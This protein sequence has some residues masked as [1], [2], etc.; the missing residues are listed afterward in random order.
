[1]RI[2]HL[3]VVAG[4]ALVTFVAGS[5]AIT[6]AQPRRA[7]PWT[8]PLL[9]LSERDIAATPEPMEASGCEARFSI[10]RRTLT[11]ARGE[12]FM[13]RTASGRHLCRIPDVQIGMGTNDRASVTC[14]G[15]Q[16]SFR[17][18]GR[19]RSPMGSDSGDWPATMT[20]RQGRTQ[21]VFAG[22]MDAGC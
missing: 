11:Y 17:R 10:G 13:I 22:T 6:S 3:S 9:P 7:A 4:A 12:Q 18:T 8:A 2:A 16:I 1:M 14:A 20:I 5:S 19:V 21:R 15:M